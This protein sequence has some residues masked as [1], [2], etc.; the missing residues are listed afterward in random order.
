MLATQPEKVVEIAVR[1]MLPKNKLGA[2]M[3][4]K[5]NVY[6]GPEHPHAAQKPEILELNIR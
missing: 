6:A 4:R 2:Q 1:G 3:Y 5:L